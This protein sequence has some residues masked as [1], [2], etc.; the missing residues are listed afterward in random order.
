MV[1]GKIQGKNG[2]N[3]E[4]IRPN[5]DGKMIQEF[6]ELRGIALRFSASCFEA[7]GRPD[8]LNAIQRTSCF[9]A[10]HTVSKMV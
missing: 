7:P 4:K 5:V 8:L 9:M 2:A 1:F 10:Y 3:F 6:L